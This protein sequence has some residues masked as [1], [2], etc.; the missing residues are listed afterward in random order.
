MILLHIMLHL[1]FYFFLF[2]LHLLMNK[3]DEKNIAFVRD[4][5]I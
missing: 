4:K 1:F 2:Y 3:V 5:N